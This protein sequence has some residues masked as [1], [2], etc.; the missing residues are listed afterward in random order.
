MTS[1]QGRLIFLDEEWEWARIG[2]MSSLMTYSSQNYGKG[3]ITVFKAYTH[4]WICNKSSSRSIRI[5]INGVIRI[6]SRYINRSCRKNWL[7]CK[8]VLNCKRIK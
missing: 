7:N 5:F 2:S 1:K 6:T 4:I 8:R 3:L